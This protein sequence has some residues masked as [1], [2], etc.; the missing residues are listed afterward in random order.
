MLDLWKQTKLMILIVLYSMMLTWFLRM[1]GKKYTQLLLIRRTQLLLNPTLNVA[2]K[3]V[4][5]G[6]GEPFPNEKLFAR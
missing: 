1:I 3:S 2:F 5:P 6:I 4:E